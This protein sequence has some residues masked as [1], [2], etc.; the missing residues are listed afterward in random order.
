MG[1][2]SEAKPDS[3]SDSASCLSSL[4]SAARFLLSTCV[5][6]IVYLVQYFE[7]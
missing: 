3:D 5:S 7:E 6:I 4:W 2:E 1:K